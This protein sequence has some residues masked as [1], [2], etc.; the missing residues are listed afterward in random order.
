MRADRQAPLADRMRPRTVD[1]VVGQTHLLR[2]GAPLRQAIESGRPPSMVF[3]GPPG[4]GKTT[5]A[6][7]IAAHTKARMVWFSAVTGGVSDVRKIIDAAQ[8]A[9]SRGERTILFVDEIHRFNKAQQDAF[10][11]HVERGTV[12][13][14]GATTENPSFEINAALLSRMRVF[15]LNVLNDADLGVLLDRALS[16]R[17]RGLGEAG[18]SIEPEA[19]TLLLQSANGDA[20]RLLSALE[21]SVEF[22]RSKG[23][24]TAGVIDKRTIAEVLGGR[25]H[26]YDKAG[27][28]HYNLISALHKSLR[29]SD[30]NASLYWL[31]RMLE[32]G[33]DPMYLARRLIRFASEDVGLADARAL[34][35]AIA[36]HDAYHALGSPEGDLALGHLVAYL[37]AA[38][39]DVRVYK[40][41]K[42]IKET[43]REMP[44]LPVPLHLRNAP[45]ALMR[46]AGYA[47]DYRYP[48]DDAEGGKG[49]KYLPPELGSVRWIELDLDE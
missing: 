18:A 44:D 39:K 25:T 4:S 34:P 48:P 3:W 2:A 43:L 41:E 13:L 32:S 12:T 37:A 8:L 23:Q 24:E 28:E 17:E 36:A 31:Y 33:E 38:P 21:L 6:A 11:P 5:L 10:L 27:E 29:G 19:R 45:T 9:L 35:L 15:I 22:L 16:D 14:I 49:Q 46:A 40:A 20:R 30:V 1:D 42:A 7:V 26:L 47:K